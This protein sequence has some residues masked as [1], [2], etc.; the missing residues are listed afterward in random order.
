MLLPDFVRN[1][2]VKQRIMFAN[3]KLDDED[4]VHIHAGVEKHINI[5]K[6]FHSCEFFRTCTSKIEAFIKEPFA[7]LE[8]PRVFFAAHLLLEL[9]LDKILMLEDQNER[10]HQLYNDY[11]KIDRSI[12]KRYWEQT[13]LQQFD[14]FWDR[15]MK[16]MEIRYVYQ[17]VHDDKLAFSLSRIYLYSKA[18]PEWT[19]RQILSVAKLIGPIQELIV[20]HVHQLKE[21]IHD[22]K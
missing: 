1:F 17:Y 14:Y 21:L 20:P 4:L 2:T 16:F 19:E 18:T 22:S 10:V 5:D 7:E 9:V 13:Q 11:E 8:I 15:F 6:I 3:H 12:L